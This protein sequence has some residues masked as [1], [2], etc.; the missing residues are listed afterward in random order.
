VLI[1][2][3]NGEFPRVSN[4]DQHFGNSRWQDRPRLN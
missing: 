2:G 3:G 1:V 4:I